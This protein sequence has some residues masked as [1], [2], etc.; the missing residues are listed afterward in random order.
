MKRGLVAAILLGL[1]L[2]TAACRQERPAPVASQPSPTVAILIETVIA[3]ETVV[4]VVTPTPPA[5]EPLTPT[6][7]AAPPTA[8]AVAQLTPTDTPTPAPT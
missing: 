2:L 8:T 5:T 1:G 4:V 7:S 3:P 6:P